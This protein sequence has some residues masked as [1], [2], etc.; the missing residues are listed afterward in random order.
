MA[1][2]WRQV[3]TN[4]DG[5]PR[6]DVQAD[7]GHVVLTGPHSRG[8]VALPDGTTYDVTAEAIEVASPEH[9]AHVS[10]EIAVQHE[11]AGRYGLSVE[12]PHECGTHCALPV[13]TPEA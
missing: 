4:D 3:G 13:N 2:H 7:S 5:S 8:E 12:N 9:A 6:Y 11:Q 10:H 1:L